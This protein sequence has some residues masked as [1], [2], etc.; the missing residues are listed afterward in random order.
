MNIRLCK[1]GDESKWIELN[2]EFMNFEIQEEGLW[3]N[4]NN[5]SYTTFQNTFIE[6]IK[7][8]ELITL[9]LIELEEELIGFANL[10]T[11]YSVWAHGKALVI[12]DLFLRPEY[13]RRGFGRKIIRYIE[14]LTKEQGYKR[15]QFQSEFSNPEACSF[16][17]SLGFEPTDMHFYTKYV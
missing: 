14:N 11:V 8:P 13:R 16:Y 6:A 10:L 17:E 9:L 12:D 1:L 2:R 7:H 3:N 4:T 5:M 15:L